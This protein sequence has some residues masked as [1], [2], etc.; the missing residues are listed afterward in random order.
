MFFTEIRDFCNQYPFWITFAYFAAFALY[1]W[2]KAIRQIASDYRASRAFYV[3]DVVKALL[4]PLRI[5]LGTLAFLL[6]LTL[7]GMS[8]C[9]HEID[10]PGETHDDWIPFSMVY[11]GWLGIGHYLVINLG[12]AA[13]VMGGLFYTLPRLWTSIKNGWNSIASHLPT[14]R[15]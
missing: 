4:W 3:R 15:W 7:N 1:G 8:P 14:V 2:P 9:T 12:V 6:M 13:M 5:P 11:G 10:C